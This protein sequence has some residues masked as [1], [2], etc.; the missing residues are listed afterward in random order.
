MWAESC[1]SA[2]ECGFRP[3][4]VPQS[5]AS[6][7][8]ALRRA[9]VAISRDCF[10]E[11]TLSKIMRFFASPRMTKSEEFAMTPHYGNLFM[12][13]TYSSNPELN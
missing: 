3:A 2:L 7:R 8:Q 9:S 10:T 1:A 4:S 6:R 11:F 13:L 12:T 5:G